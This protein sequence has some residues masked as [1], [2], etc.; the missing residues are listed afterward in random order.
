MKKVIATPAWGAI[1]IEDTDTRELSMQ[2]ICG[3][4]GMYAQRVIL[5]PEEVEEVRDGTFDADR[6][7]S[8]VCKR[9]ARVTGRLVP[10]LNSNEIPK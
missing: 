7:V 3:G 4:I 5:T 10:A 9:T 8:E 6:L 2:C 1:V